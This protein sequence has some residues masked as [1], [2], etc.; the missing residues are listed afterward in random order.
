MPAVVTVI[1]VKV[2][3]LE[4]T[5]KSKRFK[6]ILV[7][8]GTCELAA[9]ELLEIAMAGLTMVTV[10]L[11]ATG[12]VPVFVPDAKLMLLNTVEPKLIVFPPVAVEAISAVM[13]I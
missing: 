2:A 9:G 6:T 1:P 12:S 3:L 5:A 4:V 7:L 10:L 8:L 11:A 13:K